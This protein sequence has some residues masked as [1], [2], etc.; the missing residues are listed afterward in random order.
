MKS[1]GWHI[2]SVSPESSAY[3]RHVHYSGFPGMAGIEEL[4]FDVEGAGMAANIPDNG[5]HTQ[6]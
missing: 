6:S 5:T 3:S 4:P 2:R 1:H